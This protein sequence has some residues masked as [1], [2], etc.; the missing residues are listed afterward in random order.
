[1][2]FIP[3]EQLV[4]AAKQVCKVGL[5]KDDLRLALAEVT[6]F[7]VLA[8]IMLVVGV[9]MCVDDG[10]GG[11]VDAAKHFRRLATRARSR[12]MSS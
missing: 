11:G 2:S 3:T 5:T 10:G 1:M 7:E 12:S 9:G 4:G 8:V 6:A